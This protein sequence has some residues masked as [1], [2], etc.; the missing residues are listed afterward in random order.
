MRGSAPLVGGA[1]AAAAVS[2]SRV[3]GRPGW[4]GARIVWTV[5]RLPDYVYDDEGADTGGIG[6]ER[7]NTANAFGT[8]AIPAGDQR[9]GYRHQ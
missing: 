5:G 7:L 8:L 6:Y 2:C 3:A 4:P 1:S 9:S